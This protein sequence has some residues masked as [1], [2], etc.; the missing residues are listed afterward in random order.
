MDSAI[1]AEGRARRGPS[2][3]LGALLGALTILPTIALDY[4]G[5]QVAGLPF[6]PF[7]VFD[8]LARVLPGGIITV[9]IDTMVT[10]IR[11]LGLGPIS[12]TAK[13]MEQSM[14]VLIVI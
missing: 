14:G 3:I 1:N 10:V 12:A 8:W 11:T 4:L 13:S 7:D 5:A 6:V 9:G 2:L